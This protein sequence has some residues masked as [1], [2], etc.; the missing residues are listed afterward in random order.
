MGIK[1]IFRQ[2]EILWENVFEKSDKSC[3]EKYGKLI[4]FNRMYCCVVQLDQRV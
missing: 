4:K 3:D 1:I 2:L